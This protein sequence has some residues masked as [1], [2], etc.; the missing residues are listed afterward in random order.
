MGHSL[1]A[2]DDK[3]HFYMAKN[4]RLFLILS[5][6][7]SFVKCSERNDWKLIYEFKNFIS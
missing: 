5:I 2:V 1:H 3:K 6:L 4:D 7:V